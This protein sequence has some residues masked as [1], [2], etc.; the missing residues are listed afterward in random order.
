MTKLDSLFAETIDENVLTV[1][2]I[3]E[4]T[5]HFRL[6]DVVC[7]PDGREGKIVQICSSQIIFED[8]KKMKFSLPKIDCLEVRV[9]KPSGFES[10]SST[11]TLND[12]LSAIENSIHQDVPK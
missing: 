10:Y 3:N 9:I 1:N 2:K 5:S 7:L 8:N 4:M 12:L 11:T 6:G